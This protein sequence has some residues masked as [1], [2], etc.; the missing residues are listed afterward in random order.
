MQKKALFFR[1]SCGVEVQK[2][3]CRPFFICVSFCSSQEQKKEKKEKKREHFLP[4][5]CY[6]YVEEETSCILF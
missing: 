4:V 2:K 6:V 5:C 3:L 1:Q